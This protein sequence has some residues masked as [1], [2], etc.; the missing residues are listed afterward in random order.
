MATVGCG[1]NDG[2][3]FSLSLAHSA[4]TAMALLVAPKYHTL[5]VPRNWQY[6]PHF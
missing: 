4:L 1:W 6:L 2:K 3:G 5:F